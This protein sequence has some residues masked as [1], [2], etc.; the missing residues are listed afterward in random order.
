MSRQT[1]KEETA[2]IINEIIN[3]GLMDEVLTE[4]LKASIDAKKAMLTCCKEQ[5]AELKA[6]RRIADGTGDIEAIKA[7]CEENENG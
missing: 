1:K 4:L 7:L 3:K 2:K 6:I 5:R